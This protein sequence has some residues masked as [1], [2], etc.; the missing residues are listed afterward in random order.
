MHLLAARLGR[1]ACNH[2]S[3]EFVSMHFIKISNPRSSS[4]VRKNRFSVNWSCYGLEVCRAD[5]LLLGHELLDV[6]NPRVANPETEFE[7][8]IYTKT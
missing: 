8:R 1:V 6:G 5:L 3:Q 4:Q 7:R 2:D